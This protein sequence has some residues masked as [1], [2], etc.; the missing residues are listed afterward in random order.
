MFENF[1]L[2][3]LNIRENIKGIPADKNMFYV[4]HIPEL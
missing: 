1:F 3:Y 2:G 4:L